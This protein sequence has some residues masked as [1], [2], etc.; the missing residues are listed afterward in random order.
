LCCDF[1]FLPLPGL[2]RDCVLGGDEFCIGLEEGEVWN[3]AKS[4]S[5]VSDLL[6]LTG[7]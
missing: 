4:A 6:S 3:F 1:G 2:T 7:S 5:L